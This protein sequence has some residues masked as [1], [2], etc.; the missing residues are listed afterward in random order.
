MDALILSCGTGGGHD[1][2]GRAVLEAMT[3]RGHHAVMFNPYTLQ[4]SQLSNAIDKT[5]LTTARS[6]PKVFGAVYKLGDLYR[7][8]P[9]RSPVYYANHGMT[10]AMQGYLEEN[11]VDIVI[12]PH[13][14]PAEI[15]ANM[16][17]QGIPVPK[18]L[19]L[20]TD[21]VCI[22]FT[23]ETRCDAYVIPAPDLA[24]DFTGKGIPEEKL[25]PLGIPTASRF[26]QDLSQAQARQQLG[27]ASDG[28]YILIAGG[29]MGGGKL[30]QTIDALQARLSRTKNARLI[31]ICGSNRALY[32]RLL[33]RY[34]A[35]L[36]VV[37]HTD[38]MAA[39]MKAADLF[40]T[41]PGGLS[42]TEAAVCGTPI[43]HTSPIPGCENY[44]AR[45]FSQRG[46]SVFCTSGEETVT[47]ALRLLEDPQSAR[48]MSDCQQRYLEKDSAARI[49]QL[50][51][52]MVTQ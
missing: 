17:Q 39:Y 18:T 34:P 13:L 24:P 45:Y 44:N 1:S 23:E 14:F 33:A 6:A 31:V 3:A 38:E 28:K 5:Y 42:S 43:L 20:A 52:T 8:L 7:R 22:P 37:G 15:L 35:G 25:H 50:A 27:L 2:A 19:F 47:A 32:D 4:S 21:Y 48:Q 36:T 51:E 26:A 40:I 9:F 10:S 41:K 46:M 49:C 30:E 12:M 11:P 29:S 16:K